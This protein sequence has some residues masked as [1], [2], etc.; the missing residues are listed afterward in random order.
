M[1]VLGVIAA[2]QT[3][4]F[5]VTIYGVLY[6]LH[7]TLGPE[8]GHQVPPA[9]YCL[10]FLP[11]FVVLTLLAITGTALGLFLS[12][13]VSSPDRANALLPYVVIP[14]MIL[15]G[16]IIAVR[17]GVLYWLAAFLSPTYWA[18]RGVRRGM[19]LL[20]PA[21]HFHV[22]YNDSLWLTC[23]ALVAQTVVLLLLTA[24]FLK[25]KDVQTG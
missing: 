6:L 17:S 3:L 11:Q 16:G 25:R 13:S 18:Y 15:G 21:S 12:A 24:W 22:R 19:E 23:A 10:S 14:Q 2:I 4:Q 7:W 9:C 1:L 20:P 8:R 5:L